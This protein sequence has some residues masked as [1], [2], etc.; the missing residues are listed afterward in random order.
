MGDKSLDWPPFNCRSATPDGTEN[1]VRLRQ[2]ALAPKAWSKRLGPKGLAE[3]IEI[4]RLRVATDPGFVHLHV[5]SAYSLL[6][7][8]LPISKL[9]EFAKTDKQPALAL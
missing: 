6:E 3:P 5:H 1:R 9:A 2:K 7:G 8:A 4:Q